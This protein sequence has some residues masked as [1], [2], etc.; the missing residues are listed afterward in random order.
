MRCKALTWIGHAHRIVNTLVVA[1][2]TAG[3][4]KVILDCS[5]GNVA[6]Y[7]KS[8]FQRKEVH[9]VR[10][11]PECRLRHGFRDVLADD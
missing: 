7:A 8:G 3:C 10:F 2:R 4:Y 6:F 11:L 1:A 5:E 9:M